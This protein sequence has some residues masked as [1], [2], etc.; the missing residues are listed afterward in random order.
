MAVLGLCAPALIYLVFSVTQV[1]IDTVQGMFNT[2]F[3]K[4]W[5]TLVFTILL[6]FLCKTG[7]GIISWLI[8]F[9][10][11]ILMTVIVTMLLLLFGLDPRTG[12][13]R[14][15]P[16][17]AR[18]AGRPRRDER[19]K[20]RAERER[21][22]REAGDGENVQGHGTYYPEKDFNS[23]RD[24]SHTSRAQRQVLGDAVQSRTD[25][26]RDPLQRR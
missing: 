2:A 17:A 7:L 4:M 20:E 25:L 21:E 26:Q 8:V 15:R 22:R 19:K 10:P 11:F 23:G 1:S 14:V 13:L 12:R 16:V 24:E 3:L 18:E 6:N 9:I 5:V